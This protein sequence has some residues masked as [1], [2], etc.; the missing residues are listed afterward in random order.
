M[1]AFLDVS[2]IGLHRLSR[3]NGHGQELGPQ[4][5]REKASQSPP[6]TVPPPKSMNHQPPS[7]RLLLSSRISPFTP[8]PQIRRIGKAS[9]V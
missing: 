4:R 8:T 5:R 3:P 7:V 6:T 2:H 1:E 9:K